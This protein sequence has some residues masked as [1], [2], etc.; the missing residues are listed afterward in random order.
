MGKNTPDRPPRSLSSNNLKVELD[1]DAESTMLSK[2]DNNEE[3]YNEE[4]AS[5][6]LATSAETLAK[7]TGMYKDWFLRL[8]F[9][10]NTRASRS[11]NKLMD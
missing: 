10:R 2:E 6:L 4:L 11:W 3:F 5:D 9:L 8:R 1:I 7:V